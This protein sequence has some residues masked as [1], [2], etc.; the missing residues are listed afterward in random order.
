MDYAGGYQ[1]RGDGKGGKAQTYVRPGGPKGGGKD[2]NRTPWWKDAKGVTPKGKSKGKGETRECYNCGQKGHLARNCKLGKGGVNNLEEQYNE[3][4]GYY[5][6]ACEENVVEEPEEIGSLGSFVAA[7]QEEEDPKWLG[8]LNCLD[9][10]KAAGELGLIQEEWQKPKKTVRIDKDAIMMKSAKAA[11][12][13]GNICHESMWDKLKHVA[14][15]SEKKVKGLASKLEIGPVMAL[16][17]TWEAITVTADSGAGNNVAP[18]DAFPWIKLEENDDSRN[19]RYYTTANGKR[20]YVLGQK[21]IVIKT[22]E[23]IMKTMVFQICDVTRI[24]AS[25]GKIMKAGNDVLMSK[26]GSK[27][28]DAKGREIAMEM[29]NGVFVI[30]CHVKVDEASVFTRQAP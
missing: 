13:V 6:G 20:V 12:K 27:V 5:E 16:G 14:R 1:P 21:T 11:G 28:I 4:E 8:N 22:K 7:W 10:M 23:G 25:V 19:G 2:F 9:D 17:G 26:K 15:E 18:K 3:D 29:E 24:L 30:K